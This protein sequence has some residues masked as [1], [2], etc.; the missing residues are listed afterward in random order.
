MMSPNWVTISATVFLRCGR[1]SVFALAV[2]VGWQ[3]LIHCRTADVILTPS[4]IHLAL[5]AATMSD[6]IVNF[7]CVMS[8]GMIH[9]AVTAGSAIRTDKKFRVFESV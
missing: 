4:D 7:I 1:V 9:P 6:S 2:L 8:L 3:L 5:N